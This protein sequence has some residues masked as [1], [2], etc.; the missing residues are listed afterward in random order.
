MEFLLLKFLKP[1]FLKPLFLVI[2]GFLVDDHPN[3]ALI[4]FGGEQNFSAVRDFF[5]TK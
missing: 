5:D 4:I 3:F 2:V 1:S